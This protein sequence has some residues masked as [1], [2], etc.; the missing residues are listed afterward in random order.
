MKAQD[1]YQKYG[2]GNPVPSTQ[3]EWHEWYQG[4]VQWLE[5]QVEELYNVHI[6]KLK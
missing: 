3:M 1:I 2:N 6:H 4:Y 5:N